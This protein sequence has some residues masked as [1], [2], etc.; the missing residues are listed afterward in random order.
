MRIIL[1][2]L[3][4]ALLGTGC[5]TVPKSL[6]ANNLSTVTPSIVREGTGA[7]IGER[8]RWGGSILDV[9]PAATETCITVLSRPLDTTARPL[10]TDA[11]FGRFLAC[12]QGFYDPA[13]YP[14]DRSVT[15][16]GTVEGAVDGVVDGAPYRFPRLRIESLYLWPVVVY[17]PPPYYGYY[18]GGAPIW[19][20]P[21]WA[22]Y[23]YG[24][25]WGPYW[26]GPGPYWG[27]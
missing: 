18:W 12:G 21:G 7:G 23:W 26:Y 17:G 4:V 14:K 5:V 19:Y 27:W 25:N 8:V 1:A 13:V 16:L 9:K 22:P 2:A 20:G 11:T 6:Q 24:P 15:V 10:V 3:L